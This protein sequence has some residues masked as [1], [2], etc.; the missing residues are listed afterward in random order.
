MKESTESQESLAKYYVYIIICSFLACITFTLF[1]K[2][3]H[4]T[5]LIAHFV[6]LMSFTLF[7]IVLP[8]YYIHQNSN[9]KLYVKTHL[10]YPP[11][12]LPWQLPEDF[13]PG[14]VRLYV[15]KIT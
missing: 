6:H 2:L 14:S 3:Q 12:I 7:W 1:S 5:V 9:L 10:H 13:N 8:T 11:P 4:A 15:V